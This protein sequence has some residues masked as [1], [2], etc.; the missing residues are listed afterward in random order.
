MAH[1]TI[2]CTTADRKNVMRVAEERDSFQ[3]LI[4]EW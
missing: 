2:S 1:M 4:E 3:V